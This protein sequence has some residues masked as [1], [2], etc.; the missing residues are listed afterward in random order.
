MTKREKALKRIKEMT[1]ELDKIQSDIYTIL[2]DN[3]G[4]LNDVEICELEESAFDLG[5]IIYKLENI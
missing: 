1:V 4:K 3:N 2:H 5:N